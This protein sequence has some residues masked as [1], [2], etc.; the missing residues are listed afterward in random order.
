M[1]WLPGQGVGVIA[2]GNVTYAPMSALARRMLEMIDDRGLI[3]EGSI[4]AGPAM[5]E[6]A[7]RLAVLLS[8]WTE[9]GANDLFADNVAL[10]E[11]FTRRAER[12]A[13]L[14]SSHGALVVVAVDAVTP[15]RG[16]ATMHHADGVELRVD[17][18]MSPLVPPRV[19][20]YEVVE[21]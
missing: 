7:D 4:Q 6:A 18:E 1:R 17:L 3:A 8:D 10:D 12:A 19:Q 21:G 11:S 2:L 9:S 14:T 20:L 13:S 15:M 5:V 16:R